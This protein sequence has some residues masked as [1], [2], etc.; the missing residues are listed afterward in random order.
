MT[1]NPRIAPLG[2]LPLFHRLDGRRAVVVGKS[3]GAAWKAELLSAAGAHV[4]CVDGDWNEDQL[5]GAALAVADLADPENALRFIAA[6]HHAGAL[7]NL[8]D[9]PQQSDFLFGTIVNRTPVVIGI[10]TDGAAPMLGQALRSRIEVM[11]PPSLSSWARAAKD[12]RPRLKRQVDDFA[13]RRSFWQRFV[14][15]VWRELDRAPTDADFDL[16]IA[17]GI[18]QTGR[19]TFVSADIG[20]P[21]LLTLRTVRALQ[22]ATVIVHDDRF[23]RSFLDY[24]RR[25]AHRIAF[26]RSSGKRIQT[27]HEISAIVR[28]LCGAGEEVVFLASIDDPPLSQAAMLPLLE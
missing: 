23:G 21:E 11:L 22:S 7:A 24:A 5:A 6:C 26:S 17:G 8:I 16:L 1:E 10:S 13:E 27:A 15:A 20:D 25:E 2:V 14:D 9:Q 12:W 28:D 18:D 3:E 19:V 4:E